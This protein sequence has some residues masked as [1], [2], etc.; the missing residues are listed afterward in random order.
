MLAGRSGQSLLNLGFSV[1]SCGLACLQAFYVPKGLVKKN[2]SVTL[3]KEQSKAGF[4]PGAGYRDRFGGVLR[5]GR[6]G[7]QFRAQNGQVG[8]YSHREGWGQWMENHQEE[9]AGVR[10]TRATPG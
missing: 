8:I 1:P 9:T 7:A 3:V 5:W 4:A 2:Y 6:G 10:E